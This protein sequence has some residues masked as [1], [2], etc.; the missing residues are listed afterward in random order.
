M[1]D[2]EPLGVNLLAMDVTDKQQIT[3]CVVSSLC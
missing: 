1:A 3:S 2:L